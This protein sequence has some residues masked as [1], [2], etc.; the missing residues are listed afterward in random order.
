MAWK[1]AR[2]REGGGRREQTFRGERLGPVLEPGGR[3]VVPLF[4]RGGQLADL[5]VE[6]VLFVIG[7]LERALDPLR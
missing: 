5:I 3:G 6:L 4:E 7:P 2:G 1:M